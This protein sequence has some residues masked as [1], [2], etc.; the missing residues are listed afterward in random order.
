MHMLLYS[1]RPVGYSDMKLTEKQYG[2]NID[3]SPCR[4]LGAWNT[5]IHKDQGKL[6][7]V[8][9][10]RDVQNARQVRSVSPPVPG[11]L[12]PPQLYKKYGRIV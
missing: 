12:S 5:Y 3:I 8:E 11:E 2:W 4:S 1:E 9:A 7:V 6:T 10:E